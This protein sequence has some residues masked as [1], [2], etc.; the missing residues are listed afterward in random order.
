MDN[1][2]LTKILITGA[3]GFIG[4]HF[5]KYFLC[6]GHEVFSIGRT[7]VTDAT[8]Y[9]FENLL[10]VEKLTK[11]ISRVEPDYFINLI[12]DSQESNLQQ[13]FEVNTIIGDNILKAI[14]AAKL[15]EY[16]RCLFFGSSAE[17]GYVQ[18][19]NL[20]I[21]EKYYGF[22][23][24]A[25]G[26]SK[27]AQTHNAITWGEQEFGKV[28]VVRPFTVL[29]KKIPK[30]MAVGSFLSQIISIVNSNKKG[31]LRVGDLNTSRDFID[32]ED[33]VCICWKLLNSDKAYGKI[34]NVCSGKSVKIGDILNFMVDFTGVHANILISKSRLRPHDMK[35]H[36]GN[37]SQLKR[38]IGEYE[39]THWKESIKKIMSGYEKK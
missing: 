4:N 2:S 25:H 14:T 34:I 12:G 3:S 38:I 31:E 32:V 11:I 37:N 28:I 16:T 24:N 36:Y 35:N 17:Y 10:S 19:H 30:F 26:I 5:V 29:G 9:P 18:G 7:M 6:Q 22:P 20:P 33:L 1:N 27:L 21:S 23:F 39:F 8:N 13:A 15:S